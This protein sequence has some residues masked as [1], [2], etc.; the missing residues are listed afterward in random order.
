MY[1]VVVK[2][3]DRFDVEESQFDA[4]EQD[5]LSAVAIIII[6]IYYYTSCRAAG[7]LTKDIF[8][9]FKK[10]VLNNWAVITV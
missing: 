2:S 8:S 9:L 6:N 10:H 1:S 3:W 4:C 7:W 5:M